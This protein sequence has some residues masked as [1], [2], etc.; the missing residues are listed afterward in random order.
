MKIATGYGEQYAK[1][2]FQDTTY[3]LRLY[4]KYNII[5]IKYSWSRDCL[6]R[7][8]CEK[9][10]KKVHSIKNIHKTLKK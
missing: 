1:E 2:T 5:F 8:K 9:Y 10:I 6:V 7:L 4:K 3:F